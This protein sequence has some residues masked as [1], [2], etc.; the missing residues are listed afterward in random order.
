[1][2]IFLE[3]GKSAKHKT[4]CAREKPVVQQKQLSEDVIFIGRGK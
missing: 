2:Q 1:M 3:V 4:L